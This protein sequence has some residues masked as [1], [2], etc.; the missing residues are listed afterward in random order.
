ML[1]PMSRVIDVER[2][3]EW[4]DQP[5]EDTQPKPRRQQVLPAGADCE[6]A[7]VHVVNRAA[8]ERVAPSEINADVEGLLRPEEMPQEEARVDARK[9][10]AV[11]HRSSRIPGR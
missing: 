4:H 10:G 8:Y 1:R 3:E 11:L 6:I 5:I 7:A 2:V 9:R